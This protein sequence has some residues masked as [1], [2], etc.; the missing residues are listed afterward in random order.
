MEGF[1]IN[2]RRSKIYFMLVR[3]KI[4]EVKIVLKLFKNII[5]K[6]YIL[7]KQN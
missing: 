1:I 6:F 3:G 4:I 7:I 2:V 5:F